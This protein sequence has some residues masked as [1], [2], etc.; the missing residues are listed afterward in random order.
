MHHKT[1]SYQNTFGLTLIAAVAAGCGSG[2]TPSASTTSGI[3][4]HAEEVKEQ[5]IGSPD[6]ALAALK[7]GNERF[8]ARKPLHQNYLE[9]VAHTKADQHPYAAILSCLDSRVPPEIVFD[10][11]IGDV[12]VARVAG[13]IE[14]PHI[15]GSLEFA[16][17]AKGAKLVVVMGHTSCGAV[18]GA[19]KGVELGSLTGLLNEIKPAVQT[20]STAHAH[21]DKTSNEFYDHVSVE[22]VKQTVRDLSSKSPIISGLVAEGKVRIVG[23]MYD[24]SSG[25]VTFL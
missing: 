11:G 17:K 12:F 10:Q 4:H 6:A 20:V 8:V 24:L 23:A 3:A 19:C 22:N 15:V 14:D 13:N 16:T 18:I 5:N 9:Q 2:N 25:R 1:H 21:V 7:Q